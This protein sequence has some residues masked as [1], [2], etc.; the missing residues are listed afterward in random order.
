MTHVLQIIQDTVFKT[1]IQ[2]ELPHAFD[3]IINNGQ[4]EFGL[5]ELKLLNKFI[6]L[7]IEIAYAFH[8]ELKVL[9]NI[10]LI[11]K[12]YIHFLIYFG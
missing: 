8:S 7:H 9:Q 6:P 4:I 3:H 5:Q 2:K 11:H 10:T 12:T 1:F